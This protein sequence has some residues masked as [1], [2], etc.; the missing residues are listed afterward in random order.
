MLMYGLELNIASSK[1]VPLWPCALSE[2]EE[3]CVN[4]RINPTSSI[5]AYWAI[6]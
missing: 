3:I 1:K 2:N 6:A 4:F 5:E